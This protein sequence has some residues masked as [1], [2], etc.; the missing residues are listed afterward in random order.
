MLKNYLKV[1]IRNILKYKFF[2]AINILGMTL[3]VTACLF[4]ILYVSDE[5]NFDRFH[6][7]ADHIYQVGLHGRIAGQDIRTAN[8]CPPLA[9]AM[10]NEIPDVAEATRIAPFWGQAIIKNEEKAFSQDDVYYADSNFF[11]L[12]SFQLLEGDSKTAL[13][14]P[15]S[16]VLTEDMVK[17]YF[18]D[19]PVLGKLLTVGNYDKAFKVT[20]VAANC[21]LNSHFIFNVL[22]SS[23]SADHLKSN[24]WLNN[25]LYT[26]YVLGPNGSAQNVEKKLDD[27]VIKYVG[28]E[29]EQFMQVS[30]KQMK[31]QGGE[32]GFFNTRLTDIHLRATSRD[33]LRPGGDV[34]YV[35]IFGA[36]AVL[37]IFIACI[38]FM[39]LSTA[40]SAGRAKEVGLRKTLGSVRGQLIGQFLAES[41]IYSLVAVTLS[42]VACYLL[43]PSFNLVSGKELGMDVLMKPSFIGYLFALVILVGFIAGSYPA[44]Y[45]TSFSAVEVLKGKIRGGM[46]SKGIRSSLVVFQFAISIFLIIFTVIVYQQLKYMQSRDMGID[47]HNVIVLQNAY[48]LDKNMEAFKNALSQQTGVLKTS[49]TNNSFPGVNNT[50]VFKSAGSE[51]DHIMGVYF[52]DYDHLDVMRFQ[53]KEGRYFSRDFPSDSTGILLNE[54]AVKEFGFTDPLNE[55]LIY[56]DNDG[57][58]VRLKIVGV[59]KDFNF[60]SLKEQVRPLAIRLGKDGNSLMVRYA[61]NSA[62]MITSIEKLWKQYSTNEPFEYSFLDENF[63]NL[64]RS[65]QRLSYLFTIFAGLAI[66]VACLGLF[67]L[68]A[69]TAEQRT[70]EIGIRKTLGATVSNLTIL[71][72]REFTLLVIIAFVPAALIAWWLVDTWLSSF[73]YR[74]EISPSVFVLSGLAAVLLAWLTVGFQAVKTASANPVN[75][76]RYE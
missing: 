47:K 75:S 38:N 54:T 43:L 65:E 14:E 30:L 26:Y 71:L 32:Y 66:F 60:E 2:S 74:I 11:S 19:E 7:K 64:F 41:I 73:A 61:G 68:A 45:L 5:L 18:G 40:R 33:G 3:G 51:E 15:N 20:G 22:L 34:M 28:P 8:T 9:E 59:F 21:P 31:E 27:L 12:F 55:E 10:V 72:S 23:S 52:A 24:V 1:A 36:I 37:I 53:I 58:N 62:E 49:Y 29:I 6:E 48:R 16:I 76:L 56:N 42:F 69:F 35:K 44:F 70:K 4:I 39:N 46:K 25:Y 63:D 50:T 17:K 67:A 57:H 13:Q